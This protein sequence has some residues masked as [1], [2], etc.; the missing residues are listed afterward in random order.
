MSLVHFNL[1]FDLLVKFIP[2]FANATDGQASLRVCLCVPACAYTQ[3]STQTGSIRLLALAFK[4]YSP[5]RHNSL[6][7]NVTR[8]FRFSSGTVPKCDRHFG[9]FSAGLMKFAFEFHDKSVTGSVK[10]GKINF[11]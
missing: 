2:A 6:T 11:S 4:P 10:I 8:Y 1:D 7:D 9:K 3:A 5:R